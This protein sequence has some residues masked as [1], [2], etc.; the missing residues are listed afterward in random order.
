MGIDFLH[1]YKVNN[2][3]VSCMYEYAV[4]PNK[5]IQRKKKIDDEEM[6]SLYFWVGGTQSRKNP[7]LFVRVIIK[8]KRNTS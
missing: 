7:M 5:K 6:E 4:I 2:A 3:Y 8:Y 1:H